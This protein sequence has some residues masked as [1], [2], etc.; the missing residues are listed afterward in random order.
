MRII[1]GQSRGRRLA[2]LPKGGSSIRPTTD[3]VRESLFSILQSRQ[4][5]AGAH[6]L[7]IFA[8]S[9]ALGCEALSRGAASVIFMD[10]SRAAFRTILENL[11]RIQHPGE[12]ILVGDAKAL[13]R[14]LRPPRPIDLV[15]M[16]PPYNMELLAPI[17]QIL[18]KG[19]LLAPDATVVAEHHRDE[20][21]PEDLPLLAFE[22]TRSYGDTR[23]SF[24]QYTPA[25]ETP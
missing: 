22:Q 23:L 18:D 16:D 17:L 2:T 3:R 1:A 12:E 13:L 20:A 7:D 21:A 11:R 8:G 14:N 10:R 5:L 19:S 15:L 24:W 25:Q 9:G 6:V 4:L